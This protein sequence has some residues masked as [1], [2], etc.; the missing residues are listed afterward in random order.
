M[1]MKTEITA[2]LLDEMIY[3]L[4][5]RPRIT[6]PKLQQRIVDLF[7][8]V[9]EIEPQGEDGL[10]EFWINAKRGSI[11]EFGTYEEFLE[12]GDV[13]NRDE[14]ID[15]WKSYYPEEIKWYHIAFVS[16]G[17]QFFIFVDG[18]A[19]LEITDNEFH[20]TPF[21]DPSQLVDFIKKGII[22]TLDCLRSDEADYN[23]SIEKRLP[24]SK[25]FGRIK[26]S[27]YW[28]IFP[29]TREFVCGNLTKKDLDDL[30]KI[31]ESSKNRT[32]DVLM[33]D[34]TARDFFEYC[35]IGYEANDYLGD[36]KNR[37]D[38]RGMYR[39][40]ADGRDCGLCDIDPD[41]KEEFL[42]WYHHRSH[43][44][45]H[46]W[47]ISRGGNRTHISLY[48]CREEE[49]WYLA[50][51]GSSRV[52]VQ[53]TVK[54]S[55]ALF[56]NRIPFTLFEAERIIRMIKGIDYIGIVPDY[57]FPVYCGSSFPEKENIHDFMNLGYEKKEKII[58][59]AYWYPLE[60]IRLKK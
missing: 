2:P 24:F 37:M 32:P 57:I 3:H 47:E 26:R 54:M 27:D 13:E 21:E 10:R 38:A 29:E 50:L 1:D 28:E 18:R 11:D 39:A 5:D 34:L 52:R 59:R 6:E 41:S 45:G 60:P 23:S 48:V 58:E 16:H 12:S 30:D 31:A 42:D 33:K 17:G 56:R 44:G 46:P 35:K 19:A 43:C 36:T 25:R 51:A 55:L 8:L 49:G 40:L 22:K 9:C 4:K 53:E 20:S 14:F 7:D 15:L